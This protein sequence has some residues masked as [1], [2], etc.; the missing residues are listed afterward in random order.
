M[1]TH[2]ILDEY[3]NRTGWS[4]ASALSIVSDYLDAQQADDALFDYL[5]EA[6]DGEV[7]DGVRS[8][9]AL[10]DQQ[11]WTDLTLLSLYLDYIDN[12]QSPDAFRDHLSEAEALE[13]DMAAGE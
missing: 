2:V 12:Q 1:S 6:A 8:E 13:R 11:G 3:R 5:R 9:A 4:D 10:V 7:P